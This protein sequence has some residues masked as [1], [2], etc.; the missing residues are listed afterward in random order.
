M[1]ARIELDVRQVLRQIA[2]VAGNELYLSE[3]T[4]PPTEP[5]NQ[6]ASV[7]PYR[8]TADKPDSF[9]T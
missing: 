9:S 1:V 3:G 7:E 6:P 2:I 5:F 4:E 8:I